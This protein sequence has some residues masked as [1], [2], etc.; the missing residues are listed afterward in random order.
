MIFLNI[1]ELRA[2]A[3]GWEYL[4]TIDDFHNLMKKIDTYKSLDLLDETKQ[5]LSNQ[6]VRRLLVKYNI[7]VNSQVMDWLKE[8]CDDH[9]D[10]LRYVERENQW[11]GI[12]IE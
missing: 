7:V 12:V 1:D 5:T 9:R 6:E 11:R 3:L 4:F 8:Q 2:C 10:M